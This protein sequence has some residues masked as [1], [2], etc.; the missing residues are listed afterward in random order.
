MAALSIDPLLL[1][2]R[3]EFETGTIEDVSDTPKTIST[4]SGTSQSTAQFSCGAQSLLVD[5]STG[6]APHGL[7]VSDHADFSFGTGDFFILIKF[8]AQA[9]ADTTSRAPLH[10]WVA[11]SASRLGLRWNGSSTQTVRFYLADN[12]AGD[13]NDDSGTMLDVGMWHEALIQRRNGY[14]ECFL[15]GAPEVRTAVVGGGGYTQFTA[16]VDMDS[17]GLYI[18]RAGGGTTG[19]AWDGHI[20]N[21]LIGSQS[22]DIWATG[23]DVACYAD[24]PTYSGVAEVPSPLGA[25]LM[26]A[27]SFFSAVSM[28]SPLGAPAALAF[29][30]FTAALGDSITH[31]VCDLETPGGLV[32]VPISSWQATI[33]TDEAC[34][35]QCVVPACAEWI[36]DLNA[37]TEFVISRTTIFGGETF[38]YEM[39]RSPL[40]TLSLAQGPTNYSATLSGYPDALTAVADPPVVYDRTLAGVRTIFVNGANTRARASIDWLLRPGH[41]AYAGDAEI[42]VDFISYYVGGGDAYMDVGERA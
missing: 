22:F 18:G 4:G 29:H 14:W 15:N 34:Y 35:V 30:D 42:I 38:E 28:P 20:D 19:S 13:I 36:E 7:T 21:V 2:L 3:L 5:P 24:A 26:R 40:Q 1:A 41:R 6:S 10:F 12:W 16:T 17:T 11:G 25:P 23:Y 8:W 37:A 31:Y 39:A 32:R 9:D 27:L 33:Q